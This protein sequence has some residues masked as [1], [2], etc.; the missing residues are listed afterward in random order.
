ME[1][2]KKANEYKKRTYGVNFSS[3]HMAQ[4]ISSSLNYWDSEANISSSDKQ[5]HLNKSSETKR[6]TSDLQRCYCQLT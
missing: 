2:R 1:L 3:D 4:L 5:K 6:L